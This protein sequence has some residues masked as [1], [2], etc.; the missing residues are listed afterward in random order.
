MNSTSDG[1]AAALSG[2]DVNPRGDRPVLAD[3]FVADDSRAWR[4]IGFDVEADCCRIGTTTIRFVDPGEGSG[5]VAWSFRDIDAPSLDGIVTRAPVE[6]EAVADARRAGHPNTSALIDHVVVMT[7]DM[8]RTNRAFE[9]AGLEC[10][11]V[12]D[13]PGTDPVRQQGFYRSGEVVL[14]VVGPADPTGDADA[15]LW[16][17]VTVIENLD[18]AALALGDRLGSPKEAV[19]PGRR[20]AT[21]RRSAGLAVPLAFITPDPRYHASL[22]GS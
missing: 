20:I 16:G 22:G 11:R 1:S 17:L 18:E 2:P 10:R 7:P 12:R 8:A 6:A 19:Q 4:D 14:E 5:I 3:L 9:A 15:S 13:V 21:V